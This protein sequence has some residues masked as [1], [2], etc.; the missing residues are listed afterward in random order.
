[1]ITVHDIE[2]ALFDL[3]PL[4]LAMKDDKVGLQAGERHKPVRRVLVSLDVTQKVIHE[5][6]F[7]VRA[8]LIVS[9]HGIGGFRPTD[10]TDAGAVLLTLCQIG[11]ASIAMHTNL[12]AAQGGVNDVLAKLTGLTDVRIFDEKDGIGRIGKLPKPMAAR[13]F[14][15]RCKEAV[16]TG[17]VRYHD[18]GR[19]VQTVALCSGSGGSLLED[20]IRSGCD[21]FLTGEVRHNH[22][23]TARNQGV[24]LIECGHFATENVIVPVVA[25]YLRKTFPELI[26]SLSGETAEP[27]QCL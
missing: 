27:Y 5:A 12:D 8:G 16:K 1:M 15:A 24:N 3:A 22:F 9:H 2:R 4:S 18:E 19:P 7:S 10:D 25:D 14:A 13:D 17:V 21:T 6:V 26:V 11:V 23:L 20:A